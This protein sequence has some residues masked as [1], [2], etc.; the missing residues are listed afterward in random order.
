MDLAFQWDDARVLLALLRR[1]TFRAAAEE[2]GVNASTIGRRLESLE[3]ALGTRLFDRGPDGALPTAATEQL[4][5]HAERLEQAALG[6]ASAAEGFERE[7]EGIVRITAPPGLAD[8]FIAPA[9]QRLVERHPGLR[10]ELDASIGYSDLGRREADLA[11]RT[12]RPSTGDLV[13]VRLLKSSELILGGVRYAEAL[14]TLRDFADARWITWGRELD[15]L[16]SAQWVLKRVPE[17]RIVM[18]TNSIHSMLEAAE[19]GLG[20][21]LMSSG[22][23]RL[24]RLA[25]VKLTQRLRKEAAELPSLDIW[26]VGHRALRDVPRIAAVWQF[27]LEEASIQSR[28]RSIFREGP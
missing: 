18:R 10:V 13:A 15:S 11:L 21:V 7:P 19:S 23:L 12:R 6:L 20:L 22:Y 2:L 9:I 14:G 1:K 4:R 26:L 16:P 5:V 25:K 28:S 8:R 24:L 3:T 17:S 27:L